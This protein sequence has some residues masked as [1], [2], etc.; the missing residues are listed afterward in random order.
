MN[1]RTLLDR[2]HRF[3]VTTHQGADGDAI[4]SSLAFAHFLFSL[5]KQVFAVISDPLPDRYSRLLGEIEVRR[6]VPIEARDSV[7]VSLDSSDLARTV[8]PDLSFYA[9]IVNMDHH[10]TNNNFGDWNI[11]QKEASST[12]EILA[13]LI[14][15]EGFSC[16]KLVWDCLYLAIYSDTN[17][18]R[19]KNTT[20]ETLKVAAELLLRGADSEISLIF[21][22]LTLLDLK[23]L[24]EAL[25]NLQFEAPVA[26][27]V[28]G[29]SLDL[30]EGFDSDYIMNVLK[31]WSLP[32]VYVLFKETQ[33][34][35]FKVSMRAKSGI[36]LTRVAVLFGGGGH[37]AAS[38]CTV[39]GSLEEVKD[40]VLEA[41]F[42]E[43]KSA[44]RLP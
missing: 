44:R 31:S 34:G 18:F 5:K 22:E 12:G 21:S 38:G 36:D 43:I 1:L 4:G 32:G 42:H 16:P 19:F 6:E 25:R 9:Y 10:S 27:T 3:L 8:V 28:L 20:P 11:V 29:Y 30:P 39:R 13:H 7:L 26:Y 33:P 23:L 40:R 14:I 41:I 37:P 15:D 24:G 2:F 35:A 17:G